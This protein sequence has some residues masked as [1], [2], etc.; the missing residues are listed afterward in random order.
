M[1][2]TFFN[3]YF[4]YG[5]YHL[6]IQRMKKFIFF[7]YKFNTK[8]P[9]LLLLLLVYVRIL[10]AGFTLKMGKMSLSECCAVYI[11]IKVSAL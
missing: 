4:F 3:E 8:L 2:P 6:D 9:F 5:P 10:N 1:N 11:S 7:T